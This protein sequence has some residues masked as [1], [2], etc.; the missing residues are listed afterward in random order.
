MFLEV[1]IVA[2]TNPMVR[3]SMWAIFALVL[4]SERSFTRISLCLL[5]PARHMH[6]VNGAAKLACDTHPDISD[7]HLLDNTLAIM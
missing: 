1:F 7:F 5:S 4:F 3:S 2:K 6:H